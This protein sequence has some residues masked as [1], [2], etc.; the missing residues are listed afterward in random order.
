MSTRSRLALQ[1]V[2]V[3]GNRASESAASR[4]CRISC[5]DLQRHSE[6]QSTAD[7]SPYS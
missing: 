1:M 2:R 5:A 6:V 4:N 7:C 3:T